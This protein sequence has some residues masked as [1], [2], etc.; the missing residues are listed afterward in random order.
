MPLNT[1]DAEQLQTAAND[2][3]EKIRLERR[4]TI[5]LRELFR[6]MTTDLAANVE[7]TGEAQNAQIYTDDFLG[8]LSRHSRRV[9]SAF[10]GRI[11]D[12]L[13]PQFDEENSTLLAE[14]EDDNLAALILLAGAL[15]TTV[16]KMLQR[17]K[18]SVR[19]SVQAF[20]ATQAVSDTAIIT[21]TN[22]RQLDSAVADAAATLE[23]EV[24]VAPTNIAIAALAARIFLRK[25]F[26]RANT[27]ATTFTQKIAESTKNIERQAFFNLRNGF[28]AVAQGIPL[29]E[30]IEMWQTQEDDRVREN[31]FNHV[32]ANQ[33]VREGGFFTVSG[34]Q[35]A[36]PGDPNGSA[37]NIMGCRCSVIIVIE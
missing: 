26:N 28:N 27:I 9:S 25:A 35:L 10:A 31:G 19:T 6:E 5:E 13:E 23:E 15:G 36:F 16:P 18:A 24:G 22:Q 37:G 8:I 2:L 20:N 14:T 34:E 12:F 7:L 11:L 17:M 21:A 32:A 29:A 3:A 4:I 1:T 33:Q 30:E